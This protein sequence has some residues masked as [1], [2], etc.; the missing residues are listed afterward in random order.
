MRT[1]SRLLWAAI[2]SY[3]GAEDTVL[4]SVTHAVGHAAAGFARIAGGDY[5]GGGREMFS[6]LP[7]LADAA[8]SSGG[9]LDGP[10]AEVVPDGHPVLH[11]M[12]DDPWDF[13]RSPPRDLADL[14][15]ELAFRNGG[16][17]GEVSVCLVRGADGAR[18]AIVDIPGTKSWNPVPNHDITSVGTDASALDGRETAYEDGV[19][20]ALDAAGVG[21]QDEV[22]LVGHS[23]G[24]IVAVNAARHAGS[25]FRITHVVTAGSPIGRLVGRV[26]GTVQVLA[27]ENAADLVPH[28]DGAVNPDRPNVTTVTVD[29]QRGSVGADHDLMDTYQPAAAAADRSHNA[30]VDSFVRTARGFLSGDAIRTHAYRITRAF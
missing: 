9:W 6:A 14:L 13:L 15:S 2:S 17:A 26:P 3:H 25:R 4:S 11:D 5:G 8:M 28:L 18:R 24:G 22:M 7:G 12:G 21:R 29:D 10:L 27:L 16:R 20:M 30:S 19:F 23:E 1:L